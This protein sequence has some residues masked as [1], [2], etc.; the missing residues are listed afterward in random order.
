ME[1]PIFFDDDNKRKHLG[2]VKLTEDKIE[3]RINRSKSSGQE[4]L[5]EFFHFLK[6]AVRQGAHDTENLELELTSQ[7]H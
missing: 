5:L 3:V 7:E 1:G 4:E 2:K 6:M